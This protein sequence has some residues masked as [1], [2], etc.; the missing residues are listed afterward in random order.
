MAGRAA[1]LAAAALAL[2]ALPRA[3]T[4][5]SGF[6]SCLDRGKQPKAAPRA[7]GAAP[8]PVS[9]KEVDEFARE[10]AN[11]E[12]LAKEYREEI[13]ATIRKK[14]DERRRF[15]NDSYE[16]PIGTLEALDRRERQDAIQQFEEFLSRYPAD[17]TYTPDAMFRLAE[18]YYESSTEDY[19]EAL[20]RWKEDLRQAIAAG[21][22]PP[23]EPQRDYGRSVALYRKLLQAF[24]SYRFIDGTQY[25]LAYSLGEMGRQEEAL[26]AYAQL[27]ERYPKSMFVPEAWVRLGDFWFDDLRVGSLKKAAEAYAHVKGWPDHPLYA[28][29]LYKLGWTYYRLDD[30]DQAVGAFTSLLDA[31]VEQAK[32]SGKPPSG[33]VWPEAIQYTAISFADMKGDGVARAR[34]YFQLLGGRPYEALVYQRLG[35]ILFDETRYGEAVEAYK[36]FLAT[37]PL[38]PDAPKVQAKVVTA[39]QRDRRFDMEAKEREV[40]VAAYDEDGSW[41]QANRGNGDLTRD[42]RD[43]VEKNLARA[44]SF[45]HVQAQ[46]LKQQGKLPQAVEEYRAAAMAYRQYLKRFPHAKGAYELAF[47]YADALYNSLDFE[48]AAQTYAEVRDDPA[49]DKHRDEAGLSA[50]ISWE[51]EVTRRQ[52]AGQLAQLPV[53]VS[54]DRKEAELPRAIPLDAVEQSLV[55]DSDGYVDVAGAGP[56]APAIAYKAAEIFYAHNQ[57]DEARCRFEDVV[58]RWP[59]SQVAQYSANLI[60]ESYLAMKDWGAVEKAAARLQQNQV[61]K[62][63]A[64]ASSLQKFKLGGRFNRAQELMEQRQY[65]PAAAMFIALVAEDPKHE[66][67][68]KALYNAA[69][70]YESARRFESALRLYERLYADYPKSEFADDALFRVAYNAENTY[71]FEKAV[72]RYALLVEKYPKSKHRKDALYNAARSMEN[73]Q[74]YDAAAAAFA[75]YATLYPEADDA[76]RTQFHAALVYG[77]QKEWAKEVHALQEF[78]RRFARTKETGLLVQ[79]H[80]RVGLAERELGN[81]KAALQA[82]EAAVGEFARRGLKPEANPA[83]AAA[84]AEAEFRLAE[85]RFERYD[86][87]A[88]PATTNPKKL[89]QALGAK[90]AELKR[91]A[92]LYN[93]VKKYKRPDWTLAAFYRQAYM[94]ERLAQ[95]LYDAPVPPEFKK[96]GQEEYLAAYQDQLAQFAQPY[97]EQAVQVYVQALN[98]ARE[99]RVKNEWTK[100]IQESL[101]RY[102]PREYPI[103]KDAKG[104]MVLEDFSPA[105]LAESP[106]PRKRAGEPVAK[107]VP[108]AAPAPPAAP[109]GA[110]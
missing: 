10:V 44:A 14:Y 52:R 11:F 63:P 95:T 97:E 34:L 54:K 61:G 9:E 18:L 3:A 28:R 100:K 57:F 29:A 83:A 5:S 45:H 80:L 59:D 31:Y 26:R 85:S 66:F 77:K 62:N 4:P 89:K 38:S 110:N 103:L 17:P 78:L 107:T 106:E 12:A 23:E 39:W 19:N 41:F 35:D 43:M 76:A 46:A 49:D 6:T 8:A 33:D 24:P 101:A 82:Y 81:E 1:L 91:V 21:R 50:V 98:A 16:K 69:S 40:L 25:L 75:R 71:D 51:G 37:A 47:N 84:A 7:A 109:A 102:R 15:V 22:D 87:I 58:A 67:A 104:Q 64:L 94:L 42:T 53:L 30:Y 56:R 92:P 73:L 90:L 13:Q 96:A 74:R 70:C 79:A 2:P 86:R 60:I 72:E 48:G 27:I 99:L 108:A 88:L 36:A 20:A 93:E 68:D 32:K 105:P 55:R 65:E